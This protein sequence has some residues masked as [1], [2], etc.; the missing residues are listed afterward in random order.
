[1]DNK[2]I[3]RYIVEGVRMYKVPVIKII[4]IGHINIKFVFPDLNDINIDTNTEIIISQEQTE[5][6]PFFNLY[7]NNK[8]IAKKSGFFNNGTIII[9]GLC[10]FEETYRTHYDS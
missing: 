2:T 5:P 1:M 10:S 3:I 8:I 9:T 4:P 7:A 6:Y